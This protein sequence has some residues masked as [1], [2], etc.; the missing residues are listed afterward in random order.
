MIKPFADWVAA[1]LSLTVGT[2]LLVGFFDPEDQDNMTVIEDGGGSD[3]PDHPVVEDAGISFYTRGVDYFEAKTRA[4]A[5]YDLLRAYRS[6]VDITGWKIQAI[7]CGLPVYVGRDIDQR[8]GWTTSFR[9]KRQKE[10]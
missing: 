6:G 9:L 7:Y 3:E 5:I 1:Q 2:D 8:H 10:L 4:E